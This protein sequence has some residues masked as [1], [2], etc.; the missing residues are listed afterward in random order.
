MKIEENGLGWCV[1]NNI[2]LSLIA[3]KTSRTIRFEESIDLEN[4]KLQKNQE[5]MN[6]LKKECMDNKDNN[7]WKWMR[8]SDLKGC[9]K[10]LVHSPQEQSIRTNH[11][12]CNFYKTNESPHCRMCGT[13]NET[14]SYIE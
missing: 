2:E 10:S 8:K 14:V 12:K 4:S 6:R 9:N 11:I 3:V 5:K 13:K 1:K 7:T